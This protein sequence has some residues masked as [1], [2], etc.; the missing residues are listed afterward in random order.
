MLPCF[1]V[2]SLT[3]TLLFFILVLSIYLLLDEYKA[4]I[5]W[6]KIELPSSPSSPAA[7]KTPAAKTG[8]NNR[9]ITS[10]TTNHNHHHQYH[11]RIDTMRT[12]LSNRFGDK[13]IGFNTYRAALDPHGTLT[14]PLIEQLLLP[15]PSEP[16][17]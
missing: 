17:T 10:T 3:V 14:N 7:I 13:L 4:T 8:W 5:H 1:A 16:K 6:A 11:Q 15:K 9:T 2:S 12:R